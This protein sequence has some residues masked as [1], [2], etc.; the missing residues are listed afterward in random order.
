MPVLRAQHR[1]RNLPRAA[2][3]AA[4][5]AAGVR[6]PPLAPH[7]RR[8]SSRQPNPS[9]TRKPPQPPASPRL[10]GNLSSPPVRNLLL[11]PGV[12]PTGAAAPAVA[13]DPPLPGRVRESFPRLPFLARPLSSLPPLHRLP[14]SASPGASW[15]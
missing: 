6:L 9:L 7:R 8:P 15:S 3:A 4:A 13:A 11:N 10:L 5:V 1:R 12:A 14:P 2:L